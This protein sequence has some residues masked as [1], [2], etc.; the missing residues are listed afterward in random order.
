LA[1]REEGFVVEEL[2]PVDDVD[3]RT[4]AERLVRRRC[5]SPALLRLIEKLNSI[6][7]RVITSAA[8]PLAPP[9]LAVA[10]HSSFRGPPPC[11]RP[12]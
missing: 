9:D 6:L 1:L 5:G 8:L 2:P 7:Q 10:F 4:D 11:R 3:T 12:L